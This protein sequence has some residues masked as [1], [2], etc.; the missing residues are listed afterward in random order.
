[1]DEICIQLRGLNEIVYCEKLFYLMYGKGLFEANADTIDGKTAHNKREKNGKNDK[2]EDV[3]IYSFILYGYDGKLSAKLDGVLKEG[4]YYIPIEDKNSKMPEHEYEC[5]LWGHTVKTNIWI[6]DFPQIVGQMYLLNKNN[7]KCNKGKVFYRGSNSMIEIKWEKD[8]EKLIE[9]GV[10]YCISVLQNKEPSCLMD[11]D[12]CIRCSLNWICLP[13]ET[14]YINKKICEP[15]RLYPGRPDGGTLYVIKVGSKVCKNGECYQVYTPSEEKIAIPVKDV[16]NICLYG[17]TQI[18]TQA[19]TEIIQNG[20]G[21]YYFTSGGWLKCCT[22]AP[23][24]KNIHLRVAQFNKFQDQNFCLRLIQNVVISKIT[25]QRTLLRRN[26]KNDIDK[27]NVLIE[28]KREK[29]KIGNTEDVDVIRGYE[30]NCAKLY[31]KAFSNLITNKDIWTMNGRNRRPPQDEINAMLSYGYS[32]LLRDFISAIVLT[33][34]DYLYGFYH[35]VQPGRPALALDL[36]EPYRPLIV[37]SVVLRLINENIVNK[38]G[39]IK[40][41]GGI[42]MKPEIKKKIT[43]MYEKRVDEMITH[44]EFG[45]RLSYRRMMNLEAKL[46][47]KYLQGEISDYK[48]LITR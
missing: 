11:S 46:L 45:Y 41:D 7:Y 47:G 35:I 43:Y 24:T 22:L 3:N 23:V 18:T 21:V 12:K 8:Y 37:D 15:R 36:M 16:D 13:D 4:D 34:M 40:I 25:N 38:N 30:G 6:N 20:G 27:D 2:L 32:L 39:F 42:Y 33:G 26:T 1:M 9:D 14:N 10:D 19:M 29:D 31:W 28:L 44:P 48:P 5:K 17:N